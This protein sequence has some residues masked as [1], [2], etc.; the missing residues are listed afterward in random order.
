VARVETVGG[1]L[2]DADGRVL[3]GLRAPWKKAWPEH[4]DAPGGHVEPGETVAQALVRELREEIG[5][6]ADRFALVE[7]VEGAQP[8]LYGEMT[9]HIFVVT[10]WTGGEPWMACDEHSEL[11]WFTPDEVDGLPNLAGFGYPGMVRRAVAMKR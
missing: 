7:A 10:A 9:C 8:E 4:W 1:L 2:V 6:E 3:F 5:I 11:R